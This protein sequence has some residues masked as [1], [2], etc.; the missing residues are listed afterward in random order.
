MLKK[1]P[2][3][4]ETG[5]ADD[6]TTIDLALSTDVEKSVN[7][8]DSAFES[9]ALPI[10][11]RSQNPTNPELSFKTLD[12]SETKSSSNWSSNLSDKSFKTPQQE[13][14]EKS[15]KKFHEKPE[16]SFKSYQE[17]PEKSFKTE[18]S[19]K[20]SNPEPPKKEAMENVGA[21][22]AEYLNKL[23]TDERFQVTLGSEISEK[24]SENNDTTKMTFGTDFD[25]STLTEAKFRQG[26]ENSLDLSE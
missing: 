19:G 23:R 1:D 18:K 21:K 2:L 24:K 6:E 25:N 9:Q 17:K 26:L 20:K 5:P 13:K 22:V 10:S 14:S 7:E 11:S 3:E 16:T 4:I 15:F 8:D 12:L